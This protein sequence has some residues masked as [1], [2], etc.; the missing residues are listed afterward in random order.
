MAHDPRHIALRQRIEVGLALRQYPPELH[1]V[2]FAGALLLRL[3][4]VAEVKVRPLPPVPV[5]LDPYDVREL[6]P[7]I[8]EDRAEQP[9]VH[10]PAKRLEVVQ[11]SDD[12]FRVMRGQEHV[13]LVVEPSEVESQYA[14]PVPPEPPD[15]RV[16]LH[17]VLPH[18]DR[19]V[20]EVLI[21][22]PLQQG[23]RDGRCARRGCL[24]PRPVPD[25]L[26]EVHL[27][28]VARLG[29]VQEPVEGRFRDLDPVIRPDYVC[30]ALSPLQ[31]L[32]YR[33]EAANQALL[34]DVQAPPRLP[35]PRF[36]QVIGIF[37]LVE[38]VWVV[39]SAA[40]AP[41][42]GVAAVGRA[43]EPLA[44]HRLEVRAERVALPIPALPAL[45]GAQGPAEPV[46]PAIVPPRADVP[47]FDR[48]HAARALCPV[49]LHLP[50]HGGGVPP[51]R[52]RYRPDGIASVQPPLYE[53]PVVVREL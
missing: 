2:P 42:A 46:D 39:A 48:E 30:G 5:P 13:D 36:R 22:P 44:G 31:P 50:F 10:L 35:P 38:P 16:H 43:P 27:A 53:Q 1:V 37:R 29:A 32:P 14:L 8:R 21:R 15:H 24:G 49:P 11:R 34:R 18:V 12:A 23:P 4:R 7:P 26:G 9:G 45:P 6:R 33:L 51:Y 20:H 28:Q 17:G 40:E 52:A 25:G 41:I 3:R 19:E 47:G